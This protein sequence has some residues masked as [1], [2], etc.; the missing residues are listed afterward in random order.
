[1]KAFYVKHLIRERLSPK[2]N[3]TYNTFYTWIRG[4][5]RDQGCLLVWVWAIRYVGAVNI[6]NVR[7]LL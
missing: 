4:K 7:P 3:I 5:L 6:K 2:V 1:M